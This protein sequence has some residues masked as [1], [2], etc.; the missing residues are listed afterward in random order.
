MQKK[1]ISNIKEM[2][3]RDER[4]TSEFVWRSKRNVVSNRNEW[5]TAYVMCCVRDYKNTEFMYRGVAALSLGP[6]TLHPMLTNIISIPR[7]HYENILF[8]LAVHEWGA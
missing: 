1:K 4:E 2:D 6:Q 7:T 8:A 5:R 3:T